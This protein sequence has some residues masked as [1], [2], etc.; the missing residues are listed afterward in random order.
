[1]KIVIDNNILLDALLNR[2]PFHE[3]AQQILLA[4]A[5]THEGCI[6]ANSLTDIYYMLNKMTNASNAKASVKKLMGLFTVLPVSG[7]ECANA[8]LYPM[9]DF[10]DALIVECAKKA[11]ADC[12]VTRDHMFKQAVSSVQIVSTEELLPLI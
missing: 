9:D 1:M 5:E 3:P 12:I 4:C 6:T 8:L 10:E 11:K 7:E 2:T